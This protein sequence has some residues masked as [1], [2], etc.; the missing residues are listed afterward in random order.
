MSNTKE[1][2]VP[3][4]T[5][6]ATDHYEHPHKVENL[7]YADDEHEPII[8]ARTWIAVAS[9]CVWSFAQLFAIL[10]PPA[11]V[12]HASAYGGGNVLL[13]TSIKIRLAPSQLI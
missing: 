2:I 3:R 5:E 1:E 13:L 12:S 7:V 10:G 8:H 9:L 4:E 6:A 11:I